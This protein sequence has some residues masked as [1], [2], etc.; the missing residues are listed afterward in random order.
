MAMQHVHEPGLTRGQNRQSVCYE[1]CQYTE[2]VGTDPSAGPCPGG[3][4]CR[5]EQGLQI[6]GLLL[7]T[8]C[9][10]AVSM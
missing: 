4:P 5:V 1:A 6:H 3:S 9:H 2:S 8:L 7:E 10:G